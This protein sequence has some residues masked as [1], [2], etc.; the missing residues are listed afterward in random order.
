ME[1]DTDCYITVNG[2]IDRN[3]Y[4]EYIGKKI[5]VEGDVNISNLELTKIPI[6]FG[7]VTGY[8]SCSFNK[9]TSL[10]GAPKKVG[11]DFYCQHNNLTSLEY[12]PKEVGNDFDCSCNNKQFTE[13]DVGKVSKVGGNILLI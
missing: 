10:K 4:K 13:E 2:D 12:A 5:N 3:N 8:F 1:I 11:W 6:T 9:L 7:Y